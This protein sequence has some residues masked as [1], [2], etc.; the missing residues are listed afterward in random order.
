L[1]L[2]DSAYDGSNQGSQTLTVSGY[3]SNALIGTETYRLGNTATFFPQYANWT[4]EAAS[5]LAGLNLDDLE[6]TL[7]AGSNGLGDFFNQSVD[8]IV[9]AAVEPPSNVPEPGT[10]TI[11]A[12]GLLGAGAMRRR[13][14]Y[15]KNR[16]VD[17]RNR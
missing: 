16:P 3:L 9:V 2:D 1:G 15:S 13:E 11:L 4:T 8:N 17:L 12:L 14:A 10:L 5:V 7:N 6:I